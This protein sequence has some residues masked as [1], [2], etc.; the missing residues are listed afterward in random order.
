M[1][2]KL[3]LCHNINKF[4]ATM[5]AGTCPKWQPK[6]LNNEDVLRG[7]L[8]DIERTSDNRFANQL[9]KAI[10][11]ILSTKGEYHYDIQR[12]NARN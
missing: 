9:K 8:F 1:F 7:I 4:Y 5:Y 10:N 12:T 6:D 2:D 11:D 3:I